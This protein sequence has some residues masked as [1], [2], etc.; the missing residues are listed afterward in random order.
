[1]SRI[2]ERYIKLPMVAIAPSLR[3]TRKSEK[4][5]HS[6]AMIGK[7]GTVFMMPLPRIKMVRSGLSLSNSKE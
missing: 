7:S 6:A 5:K 3:L 4:K 2:K 1:M